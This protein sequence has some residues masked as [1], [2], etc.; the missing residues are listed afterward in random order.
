VTFGALVT[1]LRRTRNLSQDDLA[2]RLDVSRTIISAW[3]NDRRR[4]PADRLADLAQVLGDNHGDLA[5]LW[6]E[7]DGDAAGPHGAPGLPVTT[8]RKDAV[9]ALV[10]Y[11]STDDA[12]DDRPGYG[13]TFDLD[14]TSQ[15]LSALSTAYGLKAML[16]AGGRDWR[17]SLPR[18]RGTL[19]R[20]EL[21]GGGW[22]ASRL[23]PVARPEITAVVVSALHDAGE[24]DDEVASRIELLVDGV[25]ARVEGREP[26]RPYVLTTSLLE[27]SR[28]E[29]DDGIGRR[30]LD[31][32][33]DLS[34][35]DGEARAWPVVVKA[36][37]LSTPAPS[38]VHTA[39]AVCVLAAWARRL[40]DLRFLH[41]AQEGRLWLERHSDLSLDDELIRT[42]RPD[43]GEDYLPVHHFT[44]AW[45][46]RA[47]IEA[48]GDPSTGVA[49]RAR[50]EML[51]Y[52]VPGTALWRWP[53]GGG[54][55]PVWMTYHAL[56]A[57]MT[58]A[59]AV[60]LG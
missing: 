54:S 33:V 39:H 45:V 11:L 19:R 41:V 13:W 25:R 52:Y 1:E 42:D 44:P 16:L 8:L 10:Q 43:G 57:L 58:W 2:R 60:P 5:R 55:Y 6:G 17:V 34:Q 21:P 24:A 50:R 46:V 48:G 28:L 12:T 56:A 32:L 29:L 9:D 36:S 22:S 40:D 49:A 38:T 3:E 26:A 27:L 35:T 15:S 47:T 14:D 18:I 30:F 37:P 23:S 7:P 51:S 59:C 4:P 20:L 31:D 53:R